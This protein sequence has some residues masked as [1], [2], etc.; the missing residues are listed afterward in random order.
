MR[1]YEE[2]KTNKG[3][4]VGKIFIQK[5]L[6]YLPAKSKCFFNTRFLLIL[7]LTLFVTFELHRNTGAYVE[8]AVPVLLT[9]HS[10]NSGDV[11]TLPLLK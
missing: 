1:N 4:H 6:V 11:N 10:N 9:Y 8:L 5:S 7:V 3:V 2:K